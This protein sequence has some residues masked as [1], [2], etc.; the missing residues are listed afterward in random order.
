[1]LGWGL[2]VVW[3]CSLLVIGEV[4]VLVVVGVVV[5]VL[6]E[7]WWGWLYGVCGRRL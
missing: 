3:G 7:N 1:M 5:E 6:V 2:G 4:V